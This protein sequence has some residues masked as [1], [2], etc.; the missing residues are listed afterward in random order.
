[1]VPLPNPPKSRSG[2]TGGSAMSQTGPPGECP[3]FGKC[4]APPLGV[5]TTRA[6]RRSLGSGDPL[7]SSGRLAQS[8][9]HGQKCYRTP[10]LQPGAALDQPVVE[11]GEDLDPAA[12]EG[13]AIKRK[14]L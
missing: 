7:E 6:E 11:I 14:V 1:M 2:D 13:L 9:A 3:T 12:S 4:C 8:V 5:A 10:H